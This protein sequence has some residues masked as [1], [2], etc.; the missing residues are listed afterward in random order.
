[1]N[2][3]I[4]KA[5]RVYADDVPL[6]L[7]KKINGV[8]AVFGEKY[9]DPVRVVSIGV[10]ILDLVS[11]PANPMWHTFSVEFCGGTHLT[12]SSEAKHFVI[13]REEALAAGVRRMTALTGSAR[14][15]RTWPA[16]TWSI[17]PR[18]LSASRMTCWWLSSMRSSNFPR[19]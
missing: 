18:M 9:P 5:L 16:A 4:D 12:Q 8:R 1:M 6:E 7:A 3:W 19:S 14:R 2:A 15:R 17:A 13:L 10:P 11:N